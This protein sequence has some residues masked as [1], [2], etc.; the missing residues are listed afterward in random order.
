LY[1]QNS[2]PETDY[3]HAVISVHYNNRKLG[4]VNTFVGKLELRGLTKVPFS[5]C[6]FWL[7][8]ME[9]NTLYFLTGSTQWE[10]R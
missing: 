3:A 10:K 5:G 7:A 8:F 1:K 6:L 4:A 9:S 2:T